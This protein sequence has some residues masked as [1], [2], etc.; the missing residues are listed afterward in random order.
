VPV[1]E[2]LTNFY[3]VTMAGTRRGS[4]ALGVHTV[5]VLPFHPLRRTAEFFDEARRMKA[6]GPIQDVNVEI[7]A[8]LELESFAD[9]FGD[10]D[11]KFG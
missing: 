5:V 11:L 1:K 6:N 8:W 7:L 9:F 4:E 10:Y 2:N 3:I